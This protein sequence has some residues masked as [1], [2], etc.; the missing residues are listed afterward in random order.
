MIKP[1][2]IIL[3]LLLFTCA[4]KAQES[5][6]TQKFLSDALLPQATKETYIYTEKLWPLRYSELEHSIKDTLQGELFVPTSNPAN[7]EYIVLSKEEKGYI[8]KCLHE[9]KSKVWPDHL[10]PN[11]KLILYDTIA[12]VFKDRHKDWNYFNKHF[13]SGFHSFT[14]PIFLRNGSICLFYSDYSCGGECGSGDF[15]IY[16]KRNGVWIR[17]ITLYAWIS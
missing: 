15:S 12:N 10:F 9:Q 16:R 1:I 7:K 4:A 6:E 8:F 11:S 2:K 14:Q 5:I 13:G 3:L 17:I